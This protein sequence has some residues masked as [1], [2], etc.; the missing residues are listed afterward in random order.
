M[1]KMPP[2]ILSLY[3]WMGAHRGI[4]DD[5]RYTPDGGA[6]GNGKISRGSDDEAKHLF[7]AHGTGGP[8][9]VRSLGSV[10]AAGRRG[11]RAVFYAVST[12]SATARLFGT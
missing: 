7:I 11:R 4:H 5:R 12:L 1:P 8:A 3:E 2:P 6:L 10:R 9:Q